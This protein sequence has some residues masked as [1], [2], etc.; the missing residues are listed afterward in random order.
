MPGLI[1]S[2]VATGSVDKA[3]LDIRQADNIRPAIG[4]QRYVMAAVAVEHNALQA[5]SRILPNVRVR[6]RV[7]SSRAGHAAIEARRKP[8]S[9]INYL[10]FGMRPS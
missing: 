7:A 1:G 6:G 9:I 10:G 3:R 8:E 4:A 2:A 5:I